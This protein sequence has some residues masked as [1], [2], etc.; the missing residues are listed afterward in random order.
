MEAERALSFFRTRLGAF[1]PPSRCFVREP[2]GARAQVDR[3][4]RVLRNFSAA[5]RGG[6]VDH[7][8]GVGAALCSAM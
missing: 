8:E 4:I 3:S 6:I 1:E 7:G 5:R 2:L